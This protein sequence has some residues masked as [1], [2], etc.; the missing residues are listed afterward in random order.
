MEWSS[1][2]FQTLFTATAAN[3]LF[4]WSHDIGG[5][6]GKYYEDSAWHTEGQPGLLL[7]THARASFPCCCRAHTHVRIHELYMHMR[8]C[9][10][11]IVE[12]ER[13]RDGER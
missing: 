6:S 1:L 3:V 10:V 5:F 7:P 2:Q 4:W 13:E 8:A 11:Y 12:K 9:C